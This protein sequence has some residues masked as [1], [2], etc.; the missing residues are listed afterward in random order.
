MNLTD[1]LQRHEGKTLEFKRDFSSSANVL[2]TITAFANS[3]GGD[4]GRW[5]AE[6]EASC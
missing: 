1:L 3:A 2:K 6:Y 4:Q 5:R